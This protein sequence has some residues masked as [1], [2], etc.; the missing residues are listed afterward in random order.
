ML[1]VLALVSMRS[2]AAAQLALYR[3][4]ELSADNADAWIARLAVTPHLT[5]LV[6]TLEL[7]A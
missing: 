1:P 5:E 2:N 4:L 3:N 7:R 6:T